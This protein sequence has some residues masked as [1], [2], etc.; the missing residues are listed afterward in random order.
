M[1]EVEIE[2]RAWEGLDLPALAGR[3]GAA[4]LAHL[5][6]DPDWSATV[7]GC[8]DARIAVLNADFRGKARPTNVLSWPSAERAAAA[9]GQRPA[10]PE[11]DL[12]GDQDLGDIALA[13]GVC[14]AEAAAAARAPADHV[15]HLV[16]HGLLHLLGY[17]HETDADAALME[18][19]ER[20]VLGTLGLSDPYMDP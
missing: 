6:L 4:L 5:G 17:D 11:P 14:H 15:T 16:I 1:I 19:V 2:D 3:A 20:Q 13:Y 18:G 7:L 8:S 12:F 9:P 10:P